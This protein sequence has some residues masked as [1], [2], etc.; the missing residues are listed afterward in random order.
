MAKFCK[1]PSNPELASTD[2]LSLG[3]YRVRLPPASDHT[4]S[5]PIST[6]TCVRACSQTLHL[7]HGISSFSLDP[8][9]TVPTPA[10]RSGPGLRHKAR[11]GLLG[12][13]TPDGTSTLPLGPLKQKNHQQNPQTFGTKQTVRQAFAFSLRAETRRQSVACFDLSDPNGLIKVLTLYASPR[14]CES[15]GVLFGVTNKS[16]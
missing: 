4:F 13:R 3:K 6:H 16:R 1:I 12:H 15:T 2:P 7:I 9:P 8:R 5:A 14:D 11:P 10:W